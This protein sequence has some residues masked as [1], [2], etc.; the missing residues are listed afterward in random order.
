MKD[1]SMKKTY[2][3]TDGT[4]GFVYGRDSTH[5]NV[6]A[7]EQQTAN[8]EEGKR[9]DFDLR[10]SRPMKNTGKSSFIIE[11]VSEDQSALKW[12]FKGPV[13]FPMSLFTFIFKGILGKQLETGLQN[14][15]GVLERQ[16]LDFSSNNS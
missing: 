11:P 7:G 2:N 14:L 3:G 13:K 1:P 16:A 10:F 4:V 8:I 5:K 9:I 6:G 12:I 15:K